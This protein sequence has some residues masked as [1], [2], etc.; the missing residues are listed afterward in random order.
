MASGNPVICAE[1]G[2][3]VELIGDAG[4]SFKMDNLTVTN[5]I[6]ESIVLNTQQVWAKI[7]EYNVAAVNRVKSEFGLK[8]MASN[9]EKVFNNIRSR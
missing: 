7:E 4:K 8:K 3:T 6:L 9:Y 5:D 1:A 2:G